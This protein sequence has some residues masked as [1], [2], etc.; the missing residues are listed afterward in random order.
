MK[1]IAEM[2]VSEWESYKLDAYQFS[3]YHAFN[4][5]SELADYNKRCGNHWFD[6]DSKRFFSSRIGMIFHGQSPADW[7]I[8]ISSERNTWGN[9]PRLYTVRQL[10]IDGQ[11]ESLSEFQQYRT[12]KQAQRAIEK[13]LK[14]RTPFKTE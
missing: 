6:A 5:E 3:H 11:I 8:F 14:D 2:N 13:Y 7:N 4:S 1:K 10:Q 12:S 9:E